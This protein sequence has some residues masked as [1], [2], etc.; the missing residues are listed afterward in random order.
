MGRACAADN[1]G[2]RLHRTERTDAAV[3]DREVV[4]PVVPGVL[5]AVE[6]E[7]GEDE[8]VLEQPGLL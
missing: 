8:Q 7:V 4:V 1:S 6:V 5:H 2:R 3:H